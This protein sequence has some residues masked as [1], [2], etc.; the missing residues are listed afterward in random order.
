[1]VIFSVIL[2]DSNCP[3]PTPFS[4]YVSPIH[5]FVMGGAMDF[6]FGRRVDPRKS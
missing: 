3:K 1:M 5:M 6:K 2:N 4:H